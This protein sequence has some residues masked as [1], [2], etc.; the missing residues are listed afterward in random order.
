M[1]LLLSMG[2]KPG[3]RVNHP[4][5]PHLRLLDTRTGAVTDLLTPVPEPFHPGRREHAEFTC[6][7]LRGHTL[8]QTTRS[9]VWWIRLPDMAVTRQLSH[10]LM[11]DVHD[12]LLAPD[13]LLYVTSSGLDTVLAFDQ[14]G[15]LVARHYLGSTS[16][17]ERF[18]DRTD[19]RSLPFDHFKPHEVHP[20]HLVWMNDEP[21]FASLNARRFAPVRR[22][23]EGVVIEHGPIHDGVLHEGLLWLTTVTGHVLALDPATLAPR[24][25]LDL[26]EISDETGHL[27][28]CRG[29]AF[30]GEHLFVGMTMLR[31]SP[32]REIVRWILKGPASRKLPTRV[33]QIH[34][35]T[36]RL[37]ASHPVG[38]AA[39]GTLYSIQP[40]PEDLDPTM[41]D[42]LHVTA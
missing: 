22:P 13:G 30:H 36:R 40:W 37:V 21:W 17:E 23:H 2:I 19:F 27:G 7:K 4:L 1:R 3:G 20:N 42:N 8:L 35:P 33:L 6:A 9:S 31:N 29:L 5:R 39:G 32:Q 24:I 34:L 11:H 26:N 12:A 28:W 18:G 16:F 25:H 10:P 15:S 38:N 41:V 14:A